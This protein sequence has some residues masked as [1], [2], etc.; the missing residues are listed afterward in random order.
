VALFLKRPPRSLWTY[1]GLDAIY[2]KV[3]DYGR[4]MGKALVVAVGS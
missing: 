2:L 3:R 1:R 4:V